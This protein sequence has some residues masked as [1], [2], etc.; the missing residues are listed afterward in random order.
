MNNAQLINQDSG[1]YEYYTPMEI[2]EA[3]RKVMGGI[4]L[5]PASSLEANKR[6]RATWYYDEK[7]NGLVKPWFGRV[8]MNH[9]FG[10]GRNKAWV[11]KAVSESFELRRVD[12]FICI[13]FAATSEGWF[14]PLIMNGIQCYLTPRTNYYLPDGS[15]KRG[16]TKGSVITGWSNDNDFYRRFIETFDAF[17]QVMR[18]EWPL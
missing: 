12:S 1:D 17:G 18:P 3:A 15:L 11:M 7:S 16:V 13:T 9:P 10:R 5:D 4:D 6:V 2:V 8:W 14:Q